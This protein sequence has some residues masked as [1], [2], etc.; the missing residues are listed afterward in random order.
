VIENVEVK[1][2]RILTALVSRI[3]RVKRAN[4]MGDSGL[5]YNNDIKLVLE[6]L[7]QTVNLALEE[8][9][10]V[11]LYT[12]A[13]TRF[14]PHNE[15]AG[16]YEAHW[17]IA[18]GFGMRD[19]EGKELKDSR[20]TRL[21]NSLAQDVDIALHEGGLDLGIS[22]DVQLSLLTYQ[23]DVYSDPEVGWA[24]SGYMVRY[25]HRSYRTE[26]D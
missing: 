10:A 25:L 4:Y 7:I 1:R 5:P 24:V 13:Q 2:N 15:P 19:P 3:Q 26:E 23:Q 21:L 17:P 8:S 20:I 22:Q 11:M 6:T 9:P 18:V 14:T 12:D 16:C